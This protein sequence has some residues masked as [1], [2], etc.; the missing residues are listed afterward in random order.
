MALQAQRSRDFPFSLGANGE[1]SQG[2][3]CCILFSVLLLLPGHTGEG[4]VQHCHLK[5]IW[6]RDEI[7]EAKSSILGMS[8]EMSFDVLELVIGMV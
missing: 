6:I 7:R 5:G 3:G 1:L 4:T 2:L 8:F